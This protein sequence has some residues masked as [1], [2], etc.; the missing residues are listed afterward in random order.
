MT[1]AGTSKVYK[2][3]DLLKQ[4]ERFLAGVLVVLQPLSSTPLLLH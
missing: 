4:V 1:G 2:Y 3:C